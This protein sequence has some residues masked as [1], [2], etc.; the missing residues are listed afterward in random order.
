MISGERGQARLH[1]GI[2]LVIP[3][4]RSP[5]PRGAINQSPRLP[6][7]E[8][9]HDECRKVIGGILLMAEYWHVEHVECCVSDLM[10]GHPE[11]LSDGRI[12]RR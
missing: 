5:G 4:I 1:H 2:L 12:S 11:K 9:Q 3:Q 8:L 6:F 10:E 7:A